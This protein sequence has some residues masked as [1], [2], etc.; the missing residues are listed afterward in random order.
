MSRTPT[1]A[2][3]HLVLA[4]KLT[5]VAVLA[6][7]A[8]LAAGATG[9]GGTG[10]VTGDLSAEQQG[11]STVVHHDRVDVLMARH[12]CSASGL[13]PGV[14][15]SSALVER[16]G[17]V[18]RVSFDDGWATYTGTAPGTLVAVCRAALR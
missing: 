17:T 3:R 4:T 1:T 10:D 2:V 16:D 6:G 13:E 8:V 11:A 18:R 15:P 12:G 9:S 5:I 14:V 7:V